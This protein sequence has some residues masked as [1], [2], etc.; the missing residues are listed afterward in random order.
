MGS[1]RIELSKTYLKSKT[2]LMT[3]FD[4]Y[5]TYLAF[6]NHFTKDNFDYFKYGGKTNATTTS[7]NKRKD[8]Y[9]FEKMSRQK[10]DEDI[11]DYFT[12]IFS[13][14]DDPQKMWIGEIIETG[15]DK[16][17]DWLKKIQSLNYLFKQEMTQ[18]CDDKEFNSLFEC[19][20]GKHP[21]IVKEH[22][23]KNISTETLVILEGLLG[24]KKDF[25]SKLDDFVWK[26]VSLKLDKYKPF[27]LNNINIKKYKQTL[28]EIVIK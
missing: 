8:K 10:K 16:Y 26:T 13:Q 7:F 27:L 24:Y 4:C 1:N 18:V 2:A 3:G 6:K 17:N 23:K 14:C 5:R 12:A 28:K 21:I 22:L 20:N 25:D 9:F 19:K 11:V 15:E